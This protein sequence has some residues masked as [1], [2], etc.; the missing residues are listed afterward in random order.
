LRCA[1]ARDAR[2]VFSDGLPAPK[3]DPASFKLI[4]QRYARDR[5]RIFY[6]NTELKGVDY[7]SFEIVNARE[8][9]A[10]DKHHL[11]DCH[12]RVDAY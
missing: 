8:N 4:T 11:Y 12:Q 9:H 6:G 1:F 2:R 5:S 3:A 10:K 7:D